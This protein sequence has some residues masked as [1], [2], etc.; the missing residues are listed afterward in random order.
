MNLRRCR[1]VPTYAIDAGESSLGYRG[2]ALNDIAQLLI[3]Q[4][5]DRCT[6][7]P[8]GA[9]TGSAPGCYGADSGQGPFISEGTF[10]VASELDSGGAALMLDWTIAEHW[11]LKSTTGYREMTMISSR[12]GDGSRVSKSPA[13]T[14]RVPATRSW[15]GATSRRDNI[16]APYIAVSNESISTTVRV[17]VKVTFRPSRRISR[18]R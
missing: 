16:S 1:T 9:P 12:D 11:V 14:A 6:F 8:P 15:I 2:V 7:P 3:A 13:A 17:S 10:P 5:L 18:R 4:L